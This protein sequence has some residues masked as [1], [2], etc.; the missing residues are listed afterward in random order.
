[1][2]SVR[3]AG[4]GGPATVLAGFISSPF[5]GFFSLIL[6]GVGVLTSAGVLWGLLR[7]A[8][9]RQQLGA[10]RIFIIIFSGLAVL[11]GGTC[12]GLTAIGVGIGA[13][14]AMAR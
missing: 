11:V 5:V 13:A 7:H 9:F 10:H 14:G 1:M 4:Y 8:E 2:K 6:I 3:S 12:L